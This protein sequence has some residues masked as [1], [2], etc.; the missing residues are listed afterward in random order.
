MAPSRQR[1]MQ[2]LEETGVVAV[3]RVD[4]PA[5]LPRLAVA[6]REG[7]VR[8]IEITMTVPG[9]LDSIGATVRELGDEAFIGAGTILDPVT[10]RMAINAGAAYIV[11]PCL[12]LE[13]IE[14]AHLYGVAVIPGCLTPTEIVQAWTAGADAVKLFPGRVATPGYF[15]DLRGPLP[16]VKMMPTGNV[17]AETAP[18]YIQAGAIAVGVGKALVDAA[19]LREGDWEKIT[20]SARR[21]REVVDTA[22]GTC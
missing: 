12:N 18:Q 16:H 15:A 14:M 2:V 19:A 5:D 7:G 8:L 4:R 9:A 10:A 20:A 1:V 21:F 6:L 11:G 3:V 22:R 17:D 13:V